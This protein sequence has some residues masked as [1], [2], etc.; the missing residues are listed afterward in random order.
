MSR[1]QITAAEET[2]DIQETEE[3]NETAE[4]AESDSYTSAADIVLE[5]LRETG[6]PFAE[7][8]WLDEGNAENRTDYGV[9]EIK[10]SYILYGDDA[11]VLQTFNGAVYLYVLDGDDQKAATVQA[12]LG[13]V[14]G[15]SIRSARK[16]VLQSPI[17]NRWEWGISLTRGF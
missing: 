1:R 5:A 8:A 17:C 14:N 2:P 10:D 15:I 4:N 7:D 9:V 13:G 6:I 11:I 12:A 3:T 16:E